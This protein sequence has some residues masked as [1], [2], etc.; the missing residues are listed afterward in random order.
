ME[1]PLEDHSAR[2]G[3]PGRRINNGVVFKWIAGVLFSAVMFMLGGY[4]SGVIGQ[5][6]LRTH[7]GRMGGHPVTE[8]RLDDLEGQLNRQ[9]EAIKD[10]LDE[11]KQDI[12]ELR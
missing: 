8:Q 11:I 9:L 3:R 5:Q 6:A 4:I 1:V 7:E 2:P 10:D 12:K